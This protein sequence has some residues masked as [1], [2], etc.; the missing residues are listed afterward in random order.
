MK[1][2]RGDRRHQTFSTGFDRRALCSS[3]SGHAE[4]MSVVFTDAARRGRAVAV[5]EVGGVA[6][7]TQLARLGV[8]AKRLDAQLA[9]GRW[10]RIG[11][12][13]VLHNGPVT[14]RQ[15]EWVA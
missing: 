8:T 7:R 10:R 15:Y 3:R 2:R 5:P 12:A 13:I 9:A 1:I 6:D 14:P 11:R 4:P